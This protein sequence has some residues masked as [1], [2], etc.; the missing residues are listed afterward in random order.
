MVGAKRAAILTGEVGEV[1]FDDITRSCI[2]AKVGK[3]VLSIDNSRLQEVFIRIQ[4]QRTNFGKAAKID[5]H[6]AA[7]LGVGAEVG[8]LFQGIDDGRGEITLVIRQTSGPLSRVKVA[9]LIFTMMPGS[10]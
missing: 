1:D 9:R 10:V 4:L 6:H 2:G 7:R 5:L 3:L 8:L